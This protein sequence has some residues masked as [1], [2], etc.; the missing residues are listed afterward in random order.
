MWG[1]Y[2]SEAEHKPFAH[3]ASVVGLSDGARADLA[4]AVETFYFN[5][6]VEADPIRRALAHPETLCKKCLPPGNKREY[7]YQYVSARSREGL[8]ESSMT[9]FTT[10]RRVWQR[11]FTELFGRTRFSKHAQ[12]DTC[13]ELKAKM[14]N[15]RDANEKAQWAARYFAHQDARRP[16][17]VCVIK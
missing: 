16:T 10:F 2:S 7:Y 12:C 9:S 8:P 14:R 4:K 17:D 3:G 11:Y 15:K 13:S 6:A 5:N 1:V